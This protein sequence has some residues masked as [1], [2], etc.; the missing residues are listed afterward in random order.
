M[1]AIRDMASAENCSRDARFP[2]LSHIPIEYSWAGALCL[3]RNHVPFFREIEKRP[4]RCVLQNGL[5]PVKNTL[6]GTLAVG[7]GSELFDSCTNFTLAARLPP[8]PIAWPGI[9]TV[10]RWQEL[11]AWR[12]Q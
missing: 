1:P 6:A 2:V 10:I 4:L 12:A 3:R 9:N 7:T 8:K 5:G 11:R